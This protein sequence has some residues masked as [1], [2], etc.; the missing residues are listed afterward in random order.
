MAHIVHC[1]VC[2]TRNLVI[3]IVS[4]QLAMI[5]FLMFHFV[6]FHIS[7]A[8]NLVSVLYKTS[9]TH[10]PHASWKVLEILLENF[11]DLESPGK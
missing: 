3:S 9:Y 11:H 10:R 5:L 2:W 7:L 1:V 6:M 4:K 8:V